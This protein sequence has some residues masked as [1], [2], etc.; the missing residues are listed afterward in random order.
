MH[1]L[2]E[3]KQSSFASLSPPLADLGYDPSFILIV[4]NLRNP[5][6]NRIV[7]VPSYGLLWIKGVVCQNLCRAIR[8]Q[9]TIGDDVKV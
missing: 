8:D 7:G 4:S 1:G 3:V 2:L 5:L 9:T 6:Q